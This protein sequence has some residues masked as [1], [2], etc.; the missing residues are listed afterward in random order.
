ML[1][2]KILASSD[3]KINTSHVSNLIFSYVFVKMS[4]CCEKITL[5]NSITPIGLSHLINNIFGNNKTVHKPI[6]EIEGEIN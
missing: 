3:D 1:R 4:E 5:F 2:N 6:E